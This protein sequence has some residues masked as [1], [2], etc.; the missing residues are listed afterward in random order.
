MGDTNEQTTGATGAAP[1]GFVDRAGACRFFG[2]HP[3]TLNMWIR[4][5]RVRAPLRV[6]DSGGRRIPIYAVDALEQAKRER[7]AAAA[8]WAV[9]EGYVDRA[10][11]CA[12]FGVVEGTWVVWE[13]EGR[14]PKGEWGRSRTNRPCRIYP[15]EQLQRV[16]REIRAPDK[17]HRDHG[18]RTYHIPEGFVRLE[19]APRLF[20]VEYATFHRWEL[21]GRITCGA[22]VNGGG[23]KIY[24][25]DELERLVAEC[26]KFS[27]P[28][29]DPDRP[30]VWRVPLW[31]R[32]IRRREAIIDEADLPIVEGK[33]CHWSERGQPGKPGQVILWDGREQ[34]R[35]R[36]AI[37]G[38]RGSEWRVGH[39]NGDPLDCTRANLFMRSKQEQSRGYGKKKSYAGRP[40]SSRFKGVCWEKFTGMWCVGIAVD[41]RNIR[42]GRF[43]DEIAAAEKYDEAARELFG[44]HARLNFPD[45]VDAWL[46]Q[47]AQRAGE[48]PQREAA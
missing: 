8:N 48:A 43:H 24:P 26:G 9:P 38:V 39:R 21:E 36:Q 23:P 10:G 19:D 1:P 5:G 35:L 11:A 47:E 44:E 31:G 25:I 16:L 33:R 29:P 15:I 22:R 37:M 13:R 18:R 40:C 12:M 46:K 14:V 41:G 42:L 3:V 30:G 20:G 28:Y 17:A 32:D 27:P 7:E 4:Q 34:L 6:K 45:G 2:V